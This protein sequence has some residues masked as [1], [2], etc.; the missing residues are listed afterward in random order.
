MN[1]LLH[2]PVYN[3][4]LSRDAHLGG[5]KGL[6]RYFDEEV[7]PFVGFPL[8]H[9]QGFDELYDQLPAGRKVL[10]ATP[11]LINEPKGWQLAIEIKGLQFIFPDGTTIAKPSVQPVPL[12]KK[13]VDEMVALAT[14]TKPGPFNTRTIDFGHYHGIF[15]NGKL[16]AM[17]GQRLHPGDH[18]EVSAVCTHPDHLGKGYA[19]AL[20]LHQ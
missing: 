10:Y 5:G 13:H 18:S 1:D 6:V 4:L 3:A 17:T 2:N 15:D 11:G 14:L 16:V 20:I 19:A 9:A 8:D 7:S 12:D